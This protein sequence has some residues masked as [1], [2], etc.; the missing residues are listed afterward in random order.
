MIERVF[1]ARQ[2]AVG[3]EVAEPERLTPW[4]EFDSRLD[5]LGGAES[6]LTPLC[7]VL[8]YGGLPLQRVLAVFSRAPHPLPGYGGKS[9]GDHSLPY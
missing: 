8:R 9:P 3:W 4:A 1:F 2:G 7:R 5:W 6:G